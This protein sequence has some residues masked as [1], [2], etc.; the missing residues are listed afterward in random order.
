MSEHL[1]GEGAYG[2]VYKPALK[3]KNRK[4]EYKDSIGKVFDNKNNA[5]N[6]QTTYKSITKIDPKHKFTLPLYTNCILIKNDKYQL[7]YKYG[8]NDLNKLLQSKGSITK[9]KTFLISMGP[10]LEGIKK[11]K[12]NNYTHLDIKPENI[13][14]KNK[15]IYLIDFGLSKRLNELYTSE[16]DY[17]L[18]HI[19]PYYPP[20]F[21]LANYG[22]NFEVFYEKVKENINSY[23]R[24]SNNI[25]NIL[26]IIKITLNIPIKQQ[27]YDLFNNKRFDADKV[28]VY[29]IGIILLLFYIW[30]GLYNIN[31]KPN[32]KKYKFNLDI[33]NLI[34]NMINFNVNER[35]TI[36]QSIEKFKELIN[37][38]TTKRAC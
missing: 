5:I 16:N 31:S 28:D 14:Y 8:G 23:K 18:N 27:L 33:F 35:Y 30:S 9:L 17:I 36:E 26:E 19:Y 37:C 2:S 1:I 6:E 38:H 10:L 11:L 21:K 7:I 20:E 25:I 24:V 13:L 3:C 4:K 15:I 22:E 32:T 12:D 34:K 29:S